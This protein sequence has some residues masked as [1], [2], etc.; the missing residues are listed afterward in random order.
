[1]NKRNEEVNSRTSE[2]SP[3]ASSELRKTRTVFH[4]YPAYK[5]SGVDWLGEV[6]VGW[7]VLRLK[8]CADVMP[9]N[10]D[11][12]TNDDEAAVELCNYTDV[13]YN[14][15]ITRDIEFMKASA[16]VE[17]IR[18]FQ[19]QAGDVLLTKDSEDPNDIAVPA[20]VPETLPGVICGYHLAVARPRSVYGGYLKRFIE[21][22]FA[23]SY[24]ATR[25]NG[26]TRYGLGTYSLLNAPTPRPPLSE[27]RKIAA[28]LDFE[29]RRMDRLISRQ[30]RLIELLKEKRQAVISHA[31]TKGLDP[32]VPMK[33]SGIEW[34]G[35]V[36][37]H[38]RVGKA[39]YH[40]KVLSG[41][42]FPSAGFSHDSSDCKLL[43]G[44]NV[45]VNEIK[46]EDV[47]Y[48]TYKNGDGL[49]LFE[50]KP[51]DLVIGMDRPLIKN[52]LRVARLTE[53]D[54]PCLLL[55]RV[56]AIK[57]FTG[58]LSEYFQYF[59]SSQ[60]F[61]AH[62]SPETTGVSVPHISPEQINGFK[63]S[64]PPVDEQK[65]IVDFLQKQTELFDH[66]IKKAKSSIA[67]TAERRIALI[68]AA[69]TGKIDV[70]DWEAP[71]MYPKSPHP[72]ELRMAA[73]PD[74]EWSHD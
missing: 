34:L 2:N 33:D 26:L 68:S 3:H 58:I 54:V 59:L 56:A 6:P 60:M 62:F 70:R 19:L 23:R 15:E 27:Q 71:A 73:E 35:E 30:E 5:D 37:A 21:S 64:F 1:M 43:R 48:W 57:S 46:W 4:P 50:L 29:T 36:P 38:W 22:R 40:L 28:F 24:F 32:S 47:V 8:H 13:Y 69:V 74:V 20:Y 39:G 42:A 11:K 44:V 9:S 17:Q 18:K 49:S 10:V 67:L 7:E 14:E 66:L 25:S 63:L 55:Q 65:T 72:E 53:A 41:Y 31:V 61:V 45:G 12:K 51:G 52:G 16:S